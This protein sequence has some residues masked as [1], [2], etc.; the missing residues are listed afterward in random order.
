MT[1]GLS[2]ELMTMEIVSLGSNGRIVIFITASWIFVEYVCV[3][4]TNR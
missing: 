4:K 1:K 2:Q 3:K